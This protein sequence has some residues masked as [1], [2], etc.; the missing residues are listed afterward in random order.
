VEDGWTWLLSVYSFGGFNRQTIVSG[1]RPSLLTISPSFSSASTVLRL[2]DVGR[3]TSSVF[4]SRSTGLPP[5]ESVSSRQPCFIC[6]K[7]SFSASDKSV[8]TRATEN[9]PCRATPRDFFFAFIRAAFFFA[10]GSHTSQAAQYATP[11]RD[12]VDGRREQGT[13]NG[14]VGLCQRDS[15]TNTP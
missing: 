7:R 11:V 12:C 1:S 2:P 5:S 4:G 6:E 9:F 13:D 8:E 14:S 3:I 10:T 15:A